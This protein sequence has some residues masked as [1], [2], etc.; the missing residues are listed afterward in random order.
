MPPEEQM[1]ADMPMDDMPMD[2]MPQ[3]APS[4]AASA[5]DSILATGAATGE[6]I[7]AALEEQGFSVEAG[8]GAMGEEDPAA[9][10]EDISAEEPMDEMPM[11]EEA[12]MGRNDELLDAAK[13]GMEEDRKKKA[14]A[15]PF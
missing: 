10:L 13:F 6:E 3:E 14:S 5:I 2:E 8:A 11:D 1:S 4:D 15:P 9:G 7:L 12:P